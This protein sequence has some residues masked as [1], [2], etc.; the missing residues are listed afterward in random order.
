MRRDIA[1][2]APQAVTAPAFA[3][4]RLIGV[5]A[6]GRVA[7]RGSL[8][9]GRDGLF[10]GDGEGQRQLVGVGDASPVGGTY[11]NVTGASVNDAGQVA[12][13]AQLSSGES[14]VFV[15]DGSQATRPVRAVIREGDVVAPGDV[16]IRSLP[17]S[18]VPS[19]N[20][21]GAV[22]IRATLRQIDGGASAAVFVVGTDGGSSRVVAARDLTAVGVVVRLRDP[23][24]ADDGSLVVPASVPGEGPSLF[25]AR[26]GALTGLA[27]LGEATDLDTGPERFRFGPASVRDRAEDAVFAGSREGILIAAP[28]GVLE[29]VAF[30]GG[31]TPLGGSF[32]DFD[33][34]VADAAGVV[35]FGAEIRE[36]ERASRAIVA[37]R[38]GRLRV[39][40]RSA[41]RVTGGRLVDFF[42]AGLDPLARPDVGPAGEV[43][44]EA[45]MDGGSSPRGIFSQRGGR[46][47]AMAR[48]G[49]PAP[50]GGRFDSFGTPAVLRGAGLAFVGQVVDDGGSRDK[51]FLSRGKRVRPVAAQGGGAPGRLGGRFEAFDPPDANERLVV[52]RASLQQGGNEGLFLAKG[53]RLGLLIGSGDPAPGGGAFRSFASPALGGSSAVFLGRVAGAAGTVGLYRVAARGV[54][55]ADAAAPPIDVVGLV[56]GP[57]PAGGTITELAGFSM[58]RRDQLAVVTDL[59]DAT[60]RSV[61]FLLEPGEAVVP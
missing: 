61:L 35:A 13:R 59:V 25:V 17:S 5:S 56:G 14:G 33:P 52:F 12:F 60:A 10:Q 49:R 46:P 42:T 43:A 2:T 6:D 58:N 41:Q 39:V 27:R 4:L 7:F 11:R 23:V 31:P 32:A 44:F 24:L 57:S 29:R 36:S 19:I 18:L 1:R 47:R 28:G 3:S 37:L 45:T 15:V 40:A 20:L 54:P 38:K 26:A 53:R 22:A 9:N 51:L 48:A 34:P 21:G 8:A 50:G 30:V 55:A 16:Q